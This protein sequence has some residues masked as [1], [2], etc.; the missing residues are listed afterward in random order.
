MIWVRNSV[1]NKYD[2]RHIQRKMPL[3]KHYLLTQPEAGYFVRAL[4]QLSG[5]TQGQFAERLGVSY[6]TV[7]RW[8]NGKMQPSS[9]A[10]RQ[11]ERLALD[12][13]QG[14]T[15]L[16]HYLPSANGEQRA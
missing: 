3:K 12:L 15:L 1:N 16:E 4:R 9:L 13:N 6:E 2:A 10:L 5:L 8:E 11:L 7:S 14:Q